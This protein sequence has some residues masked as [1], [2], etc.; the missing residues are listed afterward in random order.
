MAVGVGG[1]V[2]EGDGDAPPLDGVP[3][4]LGAKCST[5]NVSTLL[6]VFMAPSFVV[7]S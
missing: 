5:T 1:I 6:K 2:G 3:D 4:L 7:Q